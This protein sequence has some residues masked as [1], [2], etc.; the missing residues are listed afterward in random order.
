MGRRVGSSV[1]LRMDG[2]IDDKLV[3]KINKWQMN[4]STVG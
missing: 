3:E 1:D 2:R 4:G